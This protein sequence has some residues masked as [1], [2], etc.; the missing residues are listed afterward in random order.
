MMESKSHE[1]FLFI[2]CR[3][4]KLTCWLYPERF[5]KPKRIQS[6]DRC[7]WNPTQLERALHHSQPEGRTR[8][9]PEKM[10][11]LLLTTEGL[12]KEVEE[13]LRVICS[14]DQ[15]RVRGE[16]GAMVEDERVATILLIEGGDQ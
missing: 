15:S 1:A 2:R 10:G 3:V 9:E 8:R 12:L 4:K 16:R 5:Q 11:T 14:L 7:L 13:E 6:N